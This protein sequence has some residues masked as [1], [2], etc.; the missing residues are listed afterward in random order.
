[1]TKYL[2]VLVSFVS[3]LFVNCLGEGDPKEASG[4]TGGSGTGG[5]S[6]AGSSSGSGGAAASGGSGGQTDCTPGKVEACTCTGSDKG[7][8]KCKDDGTGFGSCEC[9]DSG[10][11]DGSTNKCEPGKA[12]DCACAG[13]GQGTQTCAADGQ[14]L[15]KCVGCPGTDGG[16]GSGGT[17]AGTKN[18]TFTYTLPESI[19]SL[20]GVTLF[21]ILCDPA[22]G[23]CGQWTSWC[24]SNTLT[25]SEVMVQNGLT[26]TC[27]RALPVGQMAAVNVLVE[28][29]GEYV[30][31]SKGADIWACY[32][33]GASCFDSSCW[34]QYGSLVANGQ[35]ISLTDHAVANGKKVGCNFKFSY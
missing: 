23:K 24:D 25:A 8:Q 10:T 16:G 17:S 32:A 15:G 33:V 6:G 27:T 22:S 9:P 13:G 19:D 2:F 30:F 3:L 14:S 5:S 18:V 29:S 12:Y 20:K 31:P 26:F 28:A 35:T 21:G 1:M 11:P 4:S 7:T 34:T